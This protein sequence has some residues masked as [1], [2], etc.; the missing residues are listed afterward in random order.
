VLTR[1]AILLLCSS[2][3]CAGSNAGASSAA[4][5]DPDVARYRLLLRENPIDPGEAF[6]CYGGCQEQTTPDGYLSCLSQCPAFEVTQG[7]AC[8]PHEVPPVAACITARR[9]PASDKREVEPG[10]VVV[11]VLA[12]IALVV[13]LG[14]ACTEASSCGA[15]YFYPA[16][17]PNWRY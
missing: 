8:A 2:L 16:P 9:V 13:A 15:Y 4:N 6:R 14:V 12:N 1:G 11:A 5:F 7:V 3:A 17:G 10:Y